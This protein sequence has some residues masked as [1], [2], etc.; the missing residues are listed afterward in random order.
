M[1]HPSM[2]SLALTLLLIPAFPGTALAQDT[3][4]AGLS[5]TYGDWQ[6]GCQGNA[7][8]VICTMAQDV[9]ASGGTDR[10]LSAR[11]DI[12]ERSEPPR[13]SLIVPLG[14][15]VSIPLELFP[16][17]ATDPIESADIRLCQ[18]TG[19]FAFVQL[20]PELL[21]RSY[22]NTAMRVQFTPFRGE[23][24]E[25]PLSLRGFEKALERLHALQD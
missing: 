4:R 23:P 3:A 1:K 2:A 18:Q 10:L 15:D 19:C 7:G 5:E 8:T 17:T 20:T 11:V 6:V 24:S 9:R 21:A 14:I 22:E 12:A 13:L 25:V 16:G